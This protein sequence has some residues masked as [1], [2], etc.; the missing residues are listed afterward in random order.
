[1]EYFATAL[2]YGSSFEDI[3]R[4]GLTWRDLQK[5]RQIKKTK[6]E[7]RERGDGAG[8][9]GVSSS[10]H[11]HLTN[12][13]NHPLSIASVDQSVAEDMKMLGVVLDPSLT[14]HKHVSMAAQ[15]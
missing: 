8:S 7:E 11:L 4:P 10:S 3:Q 2:T 13:V 14:F 6:A 1:M 5:N 12:W 15:L 9:S